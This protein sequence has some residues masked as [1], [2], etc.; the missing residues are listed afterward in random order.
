M[1]RNKLKMLKDLNVR[2][3]TMKLLENNI[4]KGFLT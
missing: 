3:D 2:Y 1:H 4:G